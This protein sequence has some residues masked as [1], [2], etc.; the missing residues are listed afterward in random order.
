MT[1]TKYVVA[2]AA[3]S[4]ALGLTML[5]CGGSGGSCGKVQPCGGNVVGNYNISGACFDSAALS[6]EIMADCAG[7]SISISS[8][9]VSGNASFNA[10][11]TYS[12]TE[13]ISSAS[14]SEMIPASCLTTSGIT[15]TCAQLDQQIQAVVA[16]N[17]DT[18][19]SAHCAGSSSCTC[20]FALAPQTTS[21]TG[22]YTTS[23]AMITTTD[24][25]GT[26][27]APTSYC[28]QGNELHMLTVDMTMPMGKVSADLVLT[29][30]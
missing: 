20:T 12:I 17:P 14:L 2:M 5:S 29:K 16:Q 15:V 11:M 19:Q 10:D 7:A 3:V 28:V 24:N 4:A 25:L 21:E 22:T 8:F 9:N 1:Q 30:K 23:G 18:Y 6:M 26:A 27:S 13:T